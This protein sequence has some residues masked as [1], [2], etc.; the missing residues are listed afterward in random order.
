MKCVLVQYRDVLRQRR[1][2][3]IATAA[4]EALT[5]D[6]ILH[7]RDVKTL[8]NEYKENTTKNENKV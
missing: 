7:R 4:L 5:R 6:S 3:A 2:E 8:V 1:Q